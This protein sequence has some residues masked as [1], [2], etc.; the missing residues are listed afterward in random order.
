MF[1]LMALAAEGLQGA[2]PELVPIATVR[3]VMVC[4][5]RWRHLSALVA[6]LAERLDAQLMRAPFPPRREAV[7]LS[8][9]KRAAGIGDAGGHGAAG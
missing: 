6:E 3:R 8:P 1:A 5:R 4:D 9:G 7:P 2:E